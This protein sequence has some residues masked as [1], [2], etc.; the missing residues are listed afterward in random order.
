MSDEVKRLF[1]E[2]PLGISSELYGKR[3]QHL[4]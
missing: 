4:D 2:K 3:R 1:L